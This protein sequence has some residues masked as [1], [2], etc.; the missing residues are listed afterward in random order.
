MF[1]KKYIRS[2]TLC[3]SVSQGVGGKGVPESQN[4]GS[5]ISE[6]LQEMVIWQ[7]SKTDGPL[8]PLP[9]STVLVRPSRLYVENPIDNW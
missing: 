3:S 6:S 4:R 2:V 8:L 9:S 1:E 5:K 7:F